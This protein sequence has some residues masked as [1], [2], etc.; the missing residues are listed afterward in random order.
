MV[1]CYNGGLRFNQDR[2]TGVWRMDADGIARPVAMIAN[3]A[4]LVNGVWGWPMTHKEDIVK[5]WEG[6]KPAD[7]LFV[8]SDSDGD[9]IA[10]PGEIQW[11]AESHG[12]SLNHEIGGI[13]LEALVHPD[14]SFTTAYGTRVPPPKIDSRG[15][16]RY[17]LD[18]RSKVGDPEQLR[19]PLIVGERALLHQDSDGSWVGFNLVGKQRWHW[20][21]APE[22]HI[23]GPGA[24]T[25][26]TRLLG[27]AV[28]PTVGETGPCIAINGEMGAIF[29]VTMDGLFVQTLGGDARRLPPLSELNPKRGWIVEGVTFQ[30]EHFHPTINQTADGRIY[31]VAGFQ[32]GTVLRL[33]GWDGVRRRT[34]G[35]LKVTDRDLAGIPEHSIKTESKNGRPSLAVAMLSTGPKV[36]GNLDDW[37]KATQWARVDERAQA[38]A[39]VDQNNLYLA[40][41]T[42]DPQALE[43]DGRDDRALFKS[44]GALDLMLGAD[45]HAPKDRAA[46]A[47]GDL[48][49]L[50]TRNEGRTKAVLYRA[51]VPGSPG[52]D[53]VLFESPIGKTTFAQV[54]Q[55]GERVQLAQVGGDYEIAIPLELLGLKPAAGL[56]VLADLG[57]LRGREG[58]TMQRTYWSNQNATL[59]SDLPSEA[60]LVPGEWGLWTFQ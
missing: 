3:A 8:W 58:R 37:P 60:R 9:N 23:G 39:V 42:D 44:G 54:R 50:I 17:D 20:L 14:L 34:F 11:I 4:D 46:P 7:V 48:R 52:S 32:Q 1:N 13:G 27:P 35:E 16:P 28:T 38:A 55:V 6:K 57:V 47:S 43:N 31:L 33:D 5:L 19:S 29:L 21:A 22:E 25:A 2:C 26:P 24:L 53:E 12:S 41:R 56:E 10:Q 15:V 36:D 40:Y 59:V 18:R 51:L 30:Q 45:P 49:L